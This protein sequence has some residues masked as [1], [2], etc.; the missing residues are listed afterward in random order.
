MT[1]QTQQTAQTPQS[2]HRQL[3]ELTESATRQEVVLLLSPTEQLDAR[4]EY[5]VGS[6][7]QPE[8]V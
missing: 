1:Q 8:T 4:L 6:L 3:V 5:T 2:K 7:R